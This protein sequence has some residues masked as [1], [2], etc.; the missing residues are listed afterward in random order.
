ML[1]GA[2]MC[3]EHLMISKSRALEGFGGWFKSRSPP[4]PHLELSQAL[5]SLTTRSPQ[6][7][8]TGDP[9][10]L[11]SDFR[12]LLTTSRAFLQLQKASYT[13]PPSP[14][15]RVRPGSHFD[16]RRVWQQGGRGPRSRILLC[17]TAPLSSSH[18]RFLGDQR[19]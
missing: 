13:M 18:C 12:S 6:L 15:P 9:W 2:E 14:P 19:E 8:E 17:S 4:P 16:Q 10:R 7:R 1:G 5:S 3:S 11:G